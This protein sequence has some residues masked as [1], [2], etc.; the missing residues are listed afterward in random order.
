[1][2]ASEDKRSPLLQ[3]PARV[4]EIDWTVTARA[5]KWNYFLIEC[6]HDKR[7]VA[8]SG[9]FIVTPPVPSDSHEEFHEIEDADWHSGTDGEGS[10]N[11]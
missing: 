4:G 10:R 8:H 3:I 5:T 1:M 2:L 11:V 9:Y 6:S 7:V